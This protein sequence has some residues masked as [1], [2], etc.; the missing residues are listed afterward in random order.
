MQL[1]KFF[2]CRSHNQFTNN[3]A[4]N[5][6]KTLSTSTSQM[7]IRTESLPQSNCPFSYRGLIDIR[8]ILQSSFQ[9]FRGSIQLWVP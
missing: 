2:I 6:K 5:I 8:L 7:K 3:S 1:G 4:K 9:Q